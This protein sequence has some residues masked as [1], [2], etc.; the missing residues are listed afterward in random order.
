[1]LNQKKVD[2]KVLNLL[3]G[4]VKIVDYS[5]LQITWVSTSN[6]YQAWTKDITLAGYKPINFGYTVMGT[7]ASFVA[8]SAVTITASGGADIANIFMRMFTTNPTSTTQ[9]TL[10]LRVYY[11]KSDIVA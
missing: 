11:V 3:N 9:N 5:N 6:P 2:T 7:S 8:A 1:M 4:L 10:N